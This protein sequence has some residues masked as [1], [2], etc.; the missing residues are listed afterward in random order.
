MAT[1]FLFG[2]YSAEAMKGIS[3]E[4]TKDA[5]KLVQELG[6]TVQGIYALLGDKDLVIIAE[7]PGT[8]EAVRASIAI[9][10][11]TGIAFSTVPALPVSEFDQLAS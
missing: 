9:N 2:K 3:A 10:R 11:A 4:R 1:F 5:E 6:G 8:E 7:L